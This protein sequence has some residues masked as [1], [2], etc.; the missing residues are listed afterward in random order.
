MATRCDQCRQ[1]VRG[2]GHRT[3]TRT[4]CDTCYA[5]FSGLAAGYLAGGTVENAI[6]TAGWAKRIFRRRS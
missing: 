1:R 4:L 2:D 6:S 3:S 5:G